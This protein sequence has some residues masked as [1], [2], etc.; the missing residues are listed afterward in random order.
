M[1]I[2]WLLK[3][4]AIDEIK[5]YIFLVKKLIEIICSIYFLEN[6][7]LKMKDFAVFNL[8]EKEEVGGMAGV[9]AYNLHAEH[10]FSS[11]TRIQ[12]DCLATANLYYF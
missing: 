9:V 3:C 7:K 11:R 10:L 1:I 6:I 5:I 8:W 12:A 4:I 2:K